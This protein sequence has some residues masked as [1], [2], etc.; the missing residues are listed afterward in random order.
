MKLL[1]VE[2]AAEACS[3][4]LCIDGEIVERFARAPRE[5]ARLIL[6]MIDALM[7]EAG[8]TPTR[9]DAVAFGRGPGSF[10]GVRIA[11]GI[12]HGIAF[13]ADLPVV[14]VSTLAAV[15]QACL[16]DDPSDGVFAALDARMDEIYWGPYRRNSAGFAELAGRETAVSAQNAVFPEFA[17]IGAGSGW[18]R[19]GDILSLRSEG[20]VIRVSA[21]VEPRAA[22]VAKLGAYGFGRG[23]GVPVAQA[24]PVYLRDTVAKKAAER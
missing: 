22:A 15:A 23:L 12:V 6:P 24:L 18:R 3:A 4:A 8:L 20:R 14:P 11:A 9:L 2:T 1:A 5:H 21:D 13:G 16:D 7:A 10:T 17:G 19:Y